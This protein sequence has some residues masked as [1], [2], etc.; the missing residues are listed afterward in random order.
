MG[1]P[2]T[3]FDLGAA[4]VQPL[5]KFYG[6]LFR[7]TLETAAETYTRIDTRG[8]SG[9]TGGIGRSG[10]GEPWVAFYVEVDDPQAVLDRAE[11]MGAKTV[12]P[13]TELPAVTFA[14]F[15]DP[16]GLLI[17]L[18]KPMAGDSGPS[19]GEGEAVDWFEVLG[20][21]ASR[22]QSFYRELFGWN[23]D[24]DTNYAMVD[25]GAGRGAAGGIGASDKGTTWATV[26][27]SVDDVE[28]YLTRAEELGGQR[29][30]GPLDVGDNTKTGA[31]R[32]PVG[33]VFG[34]YHYTAP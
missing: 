17:G 13:V 4:N 2:V 34:L 30:Y 14:M 18:M 10:T 32:D 1:Y 27:A 26:Y 31:F 28:K 33:N 5:K 15:N 21:D 7:W 12:V 29:V 11:S 16:D 9:M 25:T 22:T 24:E 8:G 6:E 3:W 23:V 20:T 19:D